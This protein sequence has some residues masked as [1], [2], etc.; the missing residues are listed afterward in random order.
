MEINLIIKNFIKDNLIVFEDEI[1]F[2]DDDNIFEKGFVN[3][4]FAMKLLT[5]I[6]NKFGISIE[7]EDLDLK[8]FSS[9]S[10]IVN[11]INKKLS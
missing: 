11:L 4:L 10:R 7:N 6:E 2:T 9:V 8:N 5:Y 1:D 3:S